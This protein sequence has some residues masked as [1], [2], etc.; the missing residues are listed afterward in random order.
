[1]RK[2]DLN[3]IQAAIDHQ[4]DKKQQQNFEDRIQNY[5]EF[6]QEYEKWLLAKKILSNTTRAKAPR[7]FTISE[8]KALESNPFRFFFIARL[9]KTISYVAMVLFVG[10]F[11][12]QLPAFYTSDA[13]MPMMKSVQGVQENSI[14]EESIEVF[15][16]TAELDGVPSQII[17]EDTT[18]F[19]GAGGGGGMGI[20]NDDTSISGTQL[21]N[22]EE[23][24]SEKTA[25]NDA[26]QY[27]DQPQKKFDS[28]T[29]FQTYRNIIFGIILL[30]IAF[31]FWR[32]YKNLYN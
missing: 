1:M 5:L 10:L 11:I 26:E 13:A 3:L 21:R 8:Q 4:L 17:E 22:N 7:N 25:S 15:D 9:S 31:I 30:M 2:K 12:V 23:Q 29:F 6:K 27:P 18:L 32:I 28:R 16:Q 20:E 19:S 24:V 14:N